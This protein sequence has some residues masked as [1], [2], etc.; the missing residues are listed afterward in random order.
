MKSANKGDMPL[1]DYKRDLAQ[2]VAQALKEDIGDGDITAAL[3]P[4]GQTAT[5]TVICRDSA[6]LCGQAWF[7]AAFLQLD[8]ATR[9]DWLIN[10]ADEVEPGQTLCH[11]SGNAR[12][13]LT[14]ERTALNFLQTLSATATRARQYA[15]LLEDLKTRVLDTRKTLP[16]LRLA[17]KYAVTCG[18]CSN[19]R[20]G[21]FDAV[22]IKE[23]HIATAGSISQAVNNARALAADKMLEV[24][25]EDLPQLREAIEAGADR[26]LLDNMN[27]DMLKE[28]VNINA[29]RAELEASGGITLKT[30]R[31]VAESG[32]D[33][34]SIG[35]LTKDIKAIDLSMR[36]EVQQPDHG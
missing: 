19:H 16:G 4:A 3:I 1:I 23:N 13:L 18:G 31:K 2:Q 17:Q 33:F 10:D 26:V 8:P 15:R 11:I 14:A 7:D 36:V 5:A 24:E 9:I 6:T 32:V 35:S 34:I 12:V 29:G 27:P 20:I 25:V 22:L 21:L 30:I 28:A